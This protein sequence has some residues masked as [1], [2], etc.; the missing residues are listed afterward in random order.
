MGYLSVKETAQKWNVSVRRIQALC[1][2]GRIEGA[3]KVGNAYIIPNSSEKP[4]DKRKKDN[5]KK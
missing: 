5:I 4:E 1:K 3:M 2:Q